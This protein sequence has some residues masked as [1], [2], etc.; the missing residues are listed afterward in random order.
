LGR[1]WASANKGARQREK[2][3]GAQELR[4]RVAAR[5][6]GM[7]TRGLGEREARVGEPLDWTQGGRGEQAP[8]RATRREMEQGG[9]TA[10]RSTAC[11][12]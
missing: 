6:S 4:D 2:K 11:R 7:E 9:R 8:G 1:G 12:I 3:A 5:T 10:R